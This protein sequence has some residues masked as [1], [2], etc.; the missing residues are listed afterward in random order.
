MT[1]NF[2]LDIIVLAAGKG[3]RMSSKLPKVLQPLAGQP[4]LAHIISTARA[5]EPR[6]LFVVV[7][8]EAEIIQQTFADAHVDWVIQKE[9][10]GTGHAVQQA[11]PRLP[12]K[13]RTLIMYG[14]VPLLQ[15]ETLEKLI[16]EVSAGSVGVLT[17]I[18]DNPKGLGRVVRDVQGEFVNIVEEKDATW[19]QKLIQ[20]INSGIYIFPNEVLHDYL[21]KIDNINA[22][23]EYYLPP[24]LNFAK[25]AHISIQTVL[26]HNVEE[27]YG[28]NDRWQLMQAER[29]LQRRIAKE[30]TQIGVTIVDADRLDLR[31]SLIV[32]PDV[33]LDVNLIIQGEVSIDE[34]S[35]IGPN[36]LLNN[37]KIGKNVQIKSHCV[38][39]DAIIA[40]NCM[41]GPFAHIR[42]GTVLE[43]NVKVGNFVE[44][45]K[46]HLGAETK[47]NHLSYVGD[48]KVGKDV[49][50]GA[51]T[52][53]CNY[54]GKNKSVTHIGD[55]AFIGSNTALVAPVSIG[56]NAVIGAGSVITKEAP[57]GE[58][59]L[60]RA[61][62]RTIKGWR[63]SRKKID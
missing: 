52:I 47:V 38:I 26:I 17:A 31:G 34:G 25:T 40:D 36:T 15:A 13:G 33:T 21:P 41:I 37:V 39:E 46:A 12:K 60:T 55:H 58:L 59:T 48:A 22:Q 53:T 23:Q 57:A 29:L 14:D 6:N 11:L 32:E 3:T 44:L 51:G 62:Q 63:V 1:E 9:Q 27:V 24:I 54:D 35:Y 28:I 4:L 43:K 56:E 61:E 7:G 19:E 42:P 8:H 45:K 18:L 5:L 2:P 49:N 10:L 30:L 20:E 50:I 16:E